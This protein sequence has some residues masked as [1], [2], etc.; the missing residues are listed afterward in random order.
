MDSRTMIS[1]LHILVWRINNEECYMPLARPCIMD[2][3]GCQCSIDWLK[4][5][6]ASM[7]LII[8]SSALFIIPIMSYSLV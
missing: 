7:N 3:C 2:V 4:F 6:G 5:F 8:F 1:Y